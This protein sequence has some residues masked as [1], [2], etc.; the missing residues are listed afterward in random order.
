MKTI[1]IIPAREGSKRLPKKNSIEL[2]G[3]PLII[4]T[5]QYAKAHSNISSDIYVTTDSSTIESIALSYNVNVIKRPKE[6]ASDNATTVSALKHVLHVLKDDFDNVILLQPTNPLRTKNLLSD[7]FKLFSENDADSLMT[8]SRND[9]KLGKIQNGNFKPFTY[10]MG[11]RS[12]DIEPLYYENGLLYISKTDLILKDKIL[13]KK[14]IPFIINHPFAT[15]DIDTA[16]D[17]KY[18]EFILKNYKN[19]QPTYN[20]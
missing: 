14:N 5:I 2:D 18:A 19:E 10:K 3:V 7:A 15:V 9:K 20:Y 17:L 6:L 8:V 11:Q 13:G 16:E 12:Q 1:I 4:H